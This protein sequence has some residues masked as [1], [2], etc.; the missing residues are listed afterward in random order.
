MTNGFVPGPPQQPTQ[1]LP[2]E[3]ASPPPPQLP[4][5]RHIRRGQEEYSHAL[6]ALLP[7]GIAWPRWGESVVMKVIYGLSGIMGFVDGRAADLLER[8]SD[9]RQ[10]IELLPDWERNWG[11]PD[12][13]FHEA[14]TVGER[15]QMLVMKMTLLGAQSREFFISVARYLGYDATITE[16]RPF[17]VGVDRVGDNR[18]YF[19]EQGTLGE[20]PA[21]IGSANM[22]FAWTMHI[23]QPKLVWWRCSK[24]QC[25]IDP[26][27]KIQRALDLEC[28]VRAW[29]PAQTDVLFDYSKIGDPWVAT[30]RYDVLSRGGEPVTDR[31]S[32]QVINQREV[33]YVYLGANTFDLGSP[34]FGWGSLIY[35]QQPPLIHGVFTPPYS[36][37]SPTFTR[38]NMT[39]G[40]PYSLGSP[41]FA[42]PVLNTHP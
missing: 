39:I 38:P 16:Y 29:R 35:P 22:R 8:E 34:A 6:S 27:L 37:S 2:L 36:I 19:A 15:Q 13:F 21:Q 11:L 17:M 9:P 25:G 30:R 31:F 24:A 3:G 41:I 23:T 42:Y 28:V 20:W 26:H 1:P 12:C 32:E 33:F 5:D 7:Q 14:P 40:K 10:T 18:E 4:F